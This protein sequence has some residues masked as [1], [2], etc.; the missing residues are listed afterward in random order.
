MSLSN[1]LRR[2]ASR[3]QKWGDPA[4][5][6]MLRAAE[7]LDHK[8][9]QQEATREMIFAAVKF[10]EWAAGEGISP[11]RE[12]GVEAPEDFLFEW[13]S[14]YDDFS[15]DYWIEFVKRWSK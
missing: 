13:A 11:A 14:Y 12:E 7:H 9:A 4:A 6:V 15:G 3:L 1:E 5:Q 2:E 8:L 10:A